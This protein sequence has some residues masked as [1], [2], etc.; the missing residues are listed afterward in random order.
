MNR[1]EWLAVQLMVFQPANRLSLYSSSIMQ[2]QMEFSPSY[3][4]EAFKRSPQDQA[5]TN[6]VDPDDSCFQRGSYIELSSGAI[7]R[8]E[9]I[10]TEDFIQSAMR[11][12][13]F[14]LREATVVRIDHGTN[15][16]GDHVTITFSYDTQ[17][18]KVNLEVAPA[19]PLFVYGQGWA[20]CNPQAS[21]QLYE[22]RCQQ[23]QVGDICLSLVPRQPPVAPVAPPTPA[24]SQVPATAPV[25][26]N[27]YP[28]GAS[29]PPHG[30]Y[31]VPPHRNPYQMYAQ[32]ANF[33]A[34][35]TQHI[36]AEKMRQ[37]SEEQNRSDFGAEFYY[38]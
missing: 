24:L 9:D 2:L 33:V 7:R 15:G 27:D 26:A 17:H 28:V 4:Y 29:S 23:L 22:L 21:L 13:R 18:A 31:P 12:Q 10:R 19:H 14:E 36:I 3:G 34:A 6:Q 35:Y 30:A 25:T 11:N 16:G 37:R 8:V 20:S 1:P 38:N 32:M 5:A